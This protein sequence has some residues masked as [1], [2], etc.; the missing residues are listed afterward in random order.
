M[1]TEATGTAPATAP[2]LQP[3]QPHQLRSQRFQSSSQKFSDFCA[4]LWHR[5]QQ[6]PPN[7]KFN[8]EFATNGN[9]D[10]HNVRYG[11]IEDK[12]PLSL[13]RD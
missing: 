3:R 5:L 6:L 8:L 11:L 9:R 10:I 2:K 1:I 4:D 13:R 12:G 7:A